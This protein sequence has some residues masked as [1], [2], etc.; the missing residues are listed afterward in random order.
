MTAGPSAVTIETCTGAADQEW[1]I[2]ADQTVTAPTGCL[3]ATGTG[4][5]TAIIVAPCNGSTDQQ[6]LR[7]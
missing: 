2:N 5:G 3:T 4:N 7:S 6:W 1:H